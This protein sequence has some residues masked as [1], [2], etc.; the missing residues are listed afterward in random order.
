M[1]Y[2]LILFFI[3]TLWGADATLEVTKTVGTLSRLVIEDSSA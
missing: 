3:S 2:L 1:R